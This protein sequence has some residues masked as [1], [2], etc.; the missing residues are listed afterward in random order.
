MKKYLL[1]LLIPALLVIIGPA[2]R[3]NKKELTPAI[4]TGYDPRYCGCCGGLMITFTDNPAPLAAP[5]KL[6]RS[7]LADKIGNNPTFPMYVEVA[8]EVDPHKCVEFEYVTITR[9]VKR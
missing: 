9:L 2:C 5:F 4:L 7:T 3:K 6:I 8:W 1:F